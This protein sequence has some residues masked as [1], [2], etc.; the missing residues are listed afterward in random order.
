MYSNPYSHVGL[1]SLRRVDLGKGKAKDMRAKC[2]KHNFLGTIDTQKVCS[3]GA[4]LKVGSAAF[5]QG[6][7]RD[8]AMGVPKYIDCR[9][10]R[11]DCAPGRRTLHTPSYLWRN[12]HWSPWHPT[13]RSVA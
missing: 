8:E 3:L 4:P 7:G 11:K 13:T 5:F 1:A 2:R 10:S 6:T 12:R 9:G